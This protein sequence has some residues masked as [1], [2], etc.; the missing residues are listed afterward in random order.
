M[1]NARSFQRFAAVTAILSGPIAIASFVPV[2]A[3]VDFNFDAFSNL[4]LILETG[5]R[6]A[7]LWRW[8]MILDIFGY[9]LLIAPLTLLL[10]HW[11]KPRDP[12]RVN[13]YTL[14][15]LA[16][17][18]I[19]A[20]GAAI[21]AAVVPPLVVSYGADAAQNATIEMVFDAITNLVYVGLWNILEE[22]IAGVGWIG[23]GLILRRERR[24]IGITTVILGVAA[25]VDSVGTTL[26]IVALADLGLYI[27]LVLAPVWALWLGIDLLRKPVQL[28]MA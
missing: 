28:E 14:C 10:W 21:L 20:M 9:Y 13:L 6:G 16:Y 8:F 25:L 23:I 4:R 18:L 12:A 7:S 5:T 11:L 2:L 26:G 17:I 24:A 19:G 3:A 15:L 1:N 22:F 27:Y